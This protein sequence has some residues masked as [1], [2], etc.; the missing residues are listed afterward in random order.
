ML[1]RI[2][3]RAIN[4][5]Y[6]GEQHVFDWYYG[7]STAGAAR[8]EVDALGNGTENWPYMGCQWPGLWSALNDLKAEG[9]FVDFGSGKGKSLMMAGKLPYQRVIGVELNDEFAA[10]ARSNI[11]RRRAK[12]RAGLV[13]CVTDSA[14]DWK[15]P[16][17]TSVTFFF[18]PFFGATFRSTVDNVFASYDRNPRELHILYAFPWE[19][20]WLLSTGRVKVEAVT[21]EGWPKLPRWWDNDHVNVIYHV[22]STDQSVG[23][24]QLKKRR[25]SAVDQKVLLRWSKPG[26][27][28]FDVNAISQLNFE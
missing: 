26:K 9:T 28:N 7:V 12:H 10:V 20:E 15:V 8:T 5:L 2:L 22:T 16:D 18:N 13:E 3:N 11:E 14:T 24:C 25:L 27:H 23:R 19:H 1:N 21:S 17:D 6:L 4:I